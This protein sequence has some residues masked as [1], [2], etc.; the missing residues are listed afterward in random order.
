MQKS[1]IGE[2]GSHKEIA[3]KFFIK[4]ETIHPESQFAE[5]FLK[6]G[7]NVYEVIRVIDFVP[8]F[9]EDHCLRFAHSLKG[10]GVKYEWNT[11]ELIKKLDLIIQKNALKNGNIKIVYHYSRGGDSFLIIYPVQHHY[12]TKADYKTGVKTCFIEE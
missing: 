10:K 12:P 1:R 9:L 4:G 7:I 6:K 11:T 5:I 8:L 2:M 3:G